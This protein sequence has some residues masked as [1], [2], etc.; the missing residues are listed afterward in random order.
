MVINGR[1]YALLDVQMFHLHIGENL[2]DDVNCSEVF[3]ELVAEYIT[4]GCPEAAQAETYVVIQYFT[5]V[6]SHD[7]RRCVP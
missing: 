4:V 3:G 5:Q 1:I 2:V 6:M 7:R